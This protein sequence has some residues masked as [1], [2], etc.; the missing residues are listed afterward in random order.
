[1]RKR[2]EISTRRKLSTQEKASLQVDLSNL[3]EQAKSNAEAAQV[4]LQASLKLRGLVPSSLLTSNNIAAA[5]SLHDITR[6]LD[7]LS[8]SHTSYD[9]S[10]GLNAIRILVTEE[11]KDTSDRSVLSHTTKV[12]T[13]KLIKMTTGP[14]G[15]KKVGKLKGKP[16][17]I[18]RDFTE[19]TLSSAA[20]LALWILR[21]VLEKQASRTG[22]ALLLAQ[23]WIY[24]VEAIWRNSSESAAVRTTAQFLRSL[25]RVLPNSVYAELKAEPDVTKF[26]RDA[27]LA[28]LQAATNALIE[29]RLKDLETFLPLIPT[30][31]NQRDQFLAELGEICQK[32]TSEIIP[33]A[34]EWV[35][36]HTERPSSRARFPIAADESQSAALDYISVCLL[37]AWDASSEAGRAEQALEN[38]R[39][40]GRELFKV[41]LIGTPGETVNFDEQQHEL[42]SPVGQFPVQVKLI[43][44]GVRW[45]DGIRTRFLVRAIVE[46]VG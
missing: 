3:L 36:R 26:L 13:S 43:R 17:L 7:R 37:S 33:E 20:D 10:A 25:E 42:K 19:A 24:A 28:L 4:A 21:Q 15:P 8:T 35:V 41:D 44:P 45:S 46:A 23:R 34:A 5:I 12:L 6:S 1:M 38:I 27:N 2:K 16:N 9:I 29:A 11:I 39:R 40:L 22:S 18:K 32:R 14:I 31:H 30:T